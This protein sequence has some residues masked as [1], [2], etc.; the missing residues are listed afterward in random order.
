MKRQD[1]DQYAR[2]ATIYQVSR[3]RFRALMDEKPRSQADFS[4]NIAKIQI[5][6]F[7]VLESSFGMREIE[8][9]SR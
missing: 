2:L 7:A 8:R 3:E 5:W 6:K 1:G 9:G 4:A